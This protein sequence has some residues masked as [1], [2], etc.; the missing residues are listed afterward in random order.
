MDF[1]RAGRHSAAISVKLYT[2]H[3]GMMFRFYGDVLVQANPGVTEAKLVQALLAWFDMDK[4][5]RSLRLADYAYPETNE[6]HTL[7][8]QAQARKIA[9]AQAEAGATPILALAHGY[10]PADDFRRRL[11]TAWSASGHGIWIN[12]YGYLSDEK[13]AIVGDVC[14]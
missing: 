13:L 6:P 7:G 11:E 9:L 14:R 3:W 2:M 10:G 4:E 1:S 8:Q 5:P 12:R